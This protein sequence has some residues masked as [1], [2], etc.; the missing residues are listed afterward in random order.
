MTVV[1]NKNKK[2]DAILFDA[3]TGNT[4]YVDP[5][6]LEKG[7]WT[8]LY[9]ESHP[10]YYADFYVRNGLEV[11]SKG[12]RAEL[13]RLGYSCLLFRWPLNTGFTNRLT[14]VFIPRS[15]RVVVDQ[16]CV[17]SSKKKPTNLTWLASGVIDGPKMTYLRFAEPYPL[18]E[19]HQHEYGLGWRLSHGRISDARDVAKFT[20]FLVTKPDYDQVSFTKN[21]PILKFLD[22]TYVKPKRPKFFK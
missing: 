15:S 8:R 9:E 2:E 12:L 16:L 22:P 3:Y 17:I 4:P 10:E 20:P 19:V 18:I 6:K 5:D 13:K 1:K 14:F 21:L 7:V 11:I